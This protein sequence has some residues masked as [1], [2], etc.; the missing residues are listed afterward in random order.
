MKT[1]A[2]RLM[3]IYLHTCIY[4]C[5]SPTLVL[6]VG[7]QKQHVIRVYL[8]CCARE[9][10]HGKTVYVPGNDPVGGSNA[11]VADER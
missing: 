1:N 2:A 10:V 8:Y 3:N 7:T 6:F 5:V 4:E 9:S 11:V